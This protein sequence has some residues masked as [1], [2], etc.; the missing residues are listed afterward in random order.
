V[1]VADK[2]I[3]ATRDSLKAISLYDF[4]DIGLSELILPLAPGIEIDL[5]FLGHFISE[6]SAVRL[7]NARRNPS[8]DF[9]FTKGIKSGSPRLQPKTIQTRRYETRR[10]EASGGQFVPIK[11]LT[12]KEFIVEY[13]RLFLKRRGQAPMGVKNF[14]IVFGELWDLVCGDMLVLNQEPVA[15]EILYKVVNLQNICVNFVNSAV[16]M[17]HNK[18]SPGTVLLFHNISLCE[19][20]A[21]QAGKDLRFCL[22]TSLAPYKMAW[23]SCAPSFVL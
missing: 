11:S 22:G 9:A 16:D 6:L 4:I 13:T 17:S 19:E 14:D 18:L 20:K 1:R 15:I 23:C 12:I 2:H 5:P 21:L 3:L 7:K 8:F 10:L